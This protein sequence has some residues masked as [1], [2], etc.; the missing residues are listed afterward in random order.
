MN[1]RKLAHLLAV[2][3]NRSMRAAAES[4][5]LSQPALSRSLKSLE[6]ELGIELLDRSYGRVMPTSYSA[7]VLEHIRNLTAE[8]GALRET[9]RRVKGLEEGS[10]RVGFGP[11]AAATA[12]RLVARDLVSRYPK[13]KLHI[14]LANSPLLVELLQ[15][16]RL[17]VVV[18][19]S[20]YLAGEDFTVTQLSPQPVGFLAGPGH[21]LRRR[22]GRIAL[23][24]LRD[25]PV[26]APTLPPELIA[27]FRE[28]GF[29]DFPSVGCESVGLLLEVALHTPLVV[30][31]PQVVL[32]ILAEAHGLVALP[33]D[34]PFSLFAYPCVIHGR[35]RMLGPAAA[36]LKELVQQQLGPPP[37]TG[38]KPARQVKKPAPTPAASRSRIR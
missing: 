32:E 16:N 37:G 3:D 8:A 23:E 29:Q 12:L 34:A 13:L 36:L 19:D 4:V 17:D 31:V 30:M 33:V 5:H 9:V 21:P 27:T 11:F 22:R 35:G 20:R 14:E 38:R 28:N 2:I 10:I 24:E 26:G 7:P 18:C 25:Y 15:Q 6:D 1:I